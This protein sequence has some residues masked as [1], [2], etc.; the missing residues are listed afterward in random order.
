[1][2]IFVDCFLFY[3]SDFTFNSSHCECG[4]WA[5]LSLKRNGK[6]VDNLKIFIMVL[7]LRPLVLT[8]DNTQQK[9][10]YWEWAM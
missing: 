4:V 2:L 6:V 8:T 3:L 7:V 10:F 5:P 9:P 1:M